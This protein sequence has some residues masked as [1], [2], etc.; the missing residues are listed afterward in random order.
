MITIGYIY[1]TDRYAVVSHNFFYSYCQAF[2]NDKAGLLSQN[3]IAVSCHGIGMVVG[4]NKLVEYF[5]DNTEDE[6]LWILDTDIGFQANAPGML[7]D[8]ITDT[9]EDPDKLDVVV[10]ALCYGQDNNRSD[11]FGGYISEKF[12]VVYDFVRDESGLA[13]YAI[14]RDWNHGQIVQVG[15][16]GAGCLLVPRQVLL[17]VEKEYGRSWFNQV[18]YSNGE[19]V[20][21]DLS[22][23]YRLSTLGIRIFVNTNIRTSHHKAVWI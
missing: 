6:F 19:V 14:N 22:F 16:T 17:A 11:G 13:G 1:P 12:P 4:R 8:T 9:I 20:S 5:L 18:K 23:C 15:A 2:S 21:E 10:G 7:L 3:S